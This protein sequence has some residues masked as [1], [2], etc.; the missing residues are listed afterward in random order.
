VR[1][2]TKLI[3]K[4]L[5]RIG[6]HWCNQKHLIKVHSNLYRCPICERHYIRNDE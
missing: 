6:L 1:I 4:F 5:Y 2:L 3:H